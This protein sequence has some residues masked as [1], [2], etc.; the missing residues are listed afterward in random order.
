[1]KNIIAVIILMIGL[2]V[3]MANGTQMMA[4]SLTPGG[5]YR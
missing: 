1:M 5:F 4:S 3:T 2:F